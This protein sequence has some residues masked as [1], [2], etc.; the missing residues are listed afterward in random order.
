MLAGKSGVTFCGPRAIEDRATE[1]RL[2]GLIH[3]D[4][5]HHTVA[6]TRAEISGDADINAES[7]A[8]PHLAHQGKARVKTD[9]T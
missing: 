1:S 6:L 5:T 3:S 7:S 8:R 2:G 4:E 9:G